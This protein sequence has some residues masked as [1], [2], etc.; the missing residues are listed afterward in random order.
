MEENFNDRKLFSIWRNMSSSE[1]SSKLN[2]AF[3]STECSYITM[4]SLTLLFLHPTHQKGG[5]R[6]TM[7]LGS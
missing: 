3:G 6:D 2:H 5:S 1:N 4:P 7:R